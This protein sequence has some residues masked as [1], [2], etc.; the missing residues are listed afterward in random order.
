MGST[1]LTIVIVGLAVLV[2]VA[3]VLLMWRAA[4]SPRTALVAVIAGLGLAAWLLF[5]SIAAQRGFYLPPPTPAIP[6]VGVQLVLALVGMSLCLLVSPSLR[7]L[8][9]D[10]RNLIRLNVWRLVGG[11]FLGLMV[12]G[13]VPALWAVPAGVGDV[14]IGATAFWVAGGLAAPG[15]KRRA[16]IFNWLGLLDL[17]VAVGLGVTTSPGVGQ[18]FHTSPTAELLSHFPMVLVPMFLVP[19]A[20]M[21]HVVSLWQLSG[22]PWERAAPPLSESFNG[23]RSP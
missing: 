2:V 10:Q 22:R 4:T 8:L 15:G 20:V 14:L 19:L 9:T 23:A 11:V 5:T 7:G 6:P 12:A 13:Q 16:L 1:V 3:I 17:V 21:V 18:L